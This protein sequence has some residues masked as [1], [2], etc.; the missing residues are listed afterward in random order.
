MSDTNFYKLKVKQIQHVANDSVVVTFDIPSDLSEKFAYQHG[1]YVTLRFQLNGQEQRR[2]YSLCS[3]PAMDKDLQIGVKKVK[4]GIVSTHINTVLK[5]GEE[6]DVMPPQGHFTTPLSPDAKK[7]YFLFAAGSGVT[8]MFSILK[9]VIELEPKSRVFLYYGNRNEESIM[10]KD[11]LEQLEKRY[12]DQ[13]HVRHILSQPKTEKKGGFL[14]MFAKT[15]MQWAGET[16]RMTNDKIAKFVNANRA[17][18]G[19]AVECFMCGPEGM[20]TTVSNTLQLAGIDKANIHQEYFTSASAPVAASAATEGKQVIVTMG[21]KKI[22]VTLQPKETILQALIRAKANPPFSCM[23]GACSTC[24]AKV[25]SGNV[26]ME[27]CLALDES[28]VK[29]GYILSCVSTPTTDV[30]EITFDI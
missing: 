1:Q 12:R 26:K 7:D 23:S 2:A 27:R 24:M 13:L 25:T 11:E 21:G 8:P 19:R 6:V 3:S 17:E 14:G 29:Q 5:A 16:G 30:V 15:I 20:M 18:D 10:F 28:E 22:T 4:N 9:S